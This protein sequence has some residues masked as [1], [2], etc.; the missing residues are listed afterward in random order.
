MGPFLYHVRAL[1]EVLGHSPKYLPLDPPA[2]ETY[3]HSSAPVP[4]L[5]PAPMS[6]S[7]LLAVLNRAFLVVLTL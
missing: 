6:R 7:S 4:H 2:S 5:E 1:E 3:S